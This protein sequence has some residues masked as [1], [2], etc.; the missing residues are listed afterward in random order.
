MKNFH[1]C[2]DRDGQ[3]LLSARKAELRE[4]LRRQRALIPETT[5]A[6][7]TAAILEH[8]RM[9]PSLQQAKVVHT[10]VSFGEEVGTHDLIHAR[11]AAGAPVAVPK[12]IRKEKR[13]AHFFIP[14]FAAL[15]PGVL[16]ILEPSPEHG[17]IPVPAPADFEVILVPGLGFDRRGNRLGYGRGYYDR[18]LAETTGLKIAL[19][20]HCQIVAGIPV[21]AHDQR[22]DMII[23][24]QEVIRCADRH[25]VRPPRGYP[26]PV[27]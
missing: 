12:V 10:Y 14:H 11:L 17:A 15:Q 6:S 3:P 13:L 25:A 18:F 22:V 5:R 26:H 7:A 2:G 9:L 21:A 8:M 27:K 19:A 23:T 4:L 16:G 24:E 1:G 20:F